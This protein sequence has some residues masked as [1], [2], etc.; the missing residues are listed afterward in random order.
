MVLELIWCGYV[1]NE[2]NVIINMVKI[3][4]KLKKFENEI[5]NI[6]IINIV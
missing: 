6:D 1:I 5:I 4:A 3:Y 2:L